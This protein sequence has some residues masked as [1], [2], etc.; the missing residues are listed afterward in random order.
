MNQSQL[1]HSLSKGLADQDSRG[2][3]YSPSHVCIIGLLTKPVFRAGLT[4][5]KLFSAN[6]QMRVLLTGNP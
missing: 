6:I 1:P 4:R 5:P 2:I 3:L